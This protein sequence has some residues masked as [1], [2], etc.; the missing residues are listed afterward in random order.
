MKP[1]IGS[2]TADKFKMATNINHV[3]KH[4]NMMMYFSI[5]VSEFM[6]ILQRGSVS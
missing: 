4:F 5:A 2:K 3:T 1:H 6:S